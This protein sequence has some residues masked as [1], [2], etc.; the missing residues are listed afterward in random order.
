MSDIKDADPTQPIYGWDSPF[1]RNLPMVAIVRQ[2]G[3]RNGHVVISD[4]TKS[5]RVFFRVPNNLVKPSIVGN[6][7]IM[8]T[9]TA[10]DKVMGFDRLKEM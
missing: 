4:E 3:V 7:E 10:L 8:P 1:L 9:N 6:V 5:K 2:K